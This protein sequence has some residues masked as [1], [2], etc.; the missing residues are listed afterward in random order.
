MDGHHSHGGGFGNA[1]VA[2]LVVV[3]GAALLREVAVPVAKAAAPVGK[4]V[5]EFITMLTWAVGGLLVLAASGVAF[6]VVYRFRHRGDEP[7]RLTVN[8]VN[9]A[10][11]PAPASKAPMPALPPG[12]EVHHHQ[13]LHLYGPD[14]MAALGGM[15]RAQVE[16]LLAKMR[17]QIQARGEVIR[18]SPE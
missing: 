2:A 1:A 6:Y 12:G 11:V 7:R 3:I 9:P 13:H 15:D 18:R 4:S 14:P 17:G 5:A 8:R 10:Q 16:E